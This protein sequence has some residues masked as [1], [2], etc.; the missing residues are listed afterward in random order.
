MRSVDVI[1][2]K[3][4]VQLVAHTLNRF[5]D[6]IREESNNNKTKPS[7]QC[8]GSEYDV[9]QLFGES[10][11]YLKNAEAINNIVNPKK[12]LLAQYKERFRLALVMGKSHVKADETA[13]KKATCS[14]IKYFEDE[15]YLEDSKA[16][17]GIFNA[18]EDKDETLAELNPGDQYFKVLI[19]ILY[20]ISPY[21]KD[22]KTESDILRVLARYISEAKRQKKAALRLQR[23][24]DKPENIGKV[25]GLTPSFWSLFRKRISSIFSKK[26]K[27]A[28]TEDQSQTKKKTGFFR[29]LLDLGRGR[30]IGGLMRNSIS[31]DIGDIGTPKVTDDRTKQAL[32]KSCVMIQ[33][34]R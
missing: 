3:V 9:T 16:I 8:S 23:L 27:R 19:A 30:G 12:D 10:E 29:L 13:D 33:H 26:P 34:K 25:L 20:S 24:L 15:E 17:A 14:A 32:L 6:I 7:E 31:I 18:K 2:D 21:V 22:N 4:D 1:K 5:A 11:Y 28:K